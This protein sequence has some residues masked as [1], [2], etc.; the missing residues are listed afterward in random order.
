MT[1]RIQPGTTVTWSSQ[2]NSSTKKKTGTIIAFVPAGRDVFFLPE[3]EALTLW[4]RQF[5]VPV[6]AVDRYLVRVD[7]QG[8]RHI[9][10]PVYYLPLAGALERQNKP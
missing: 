2:A 3:T 1:N 4:P 5:D 8:K 6:A 7:R 10:A 9:L